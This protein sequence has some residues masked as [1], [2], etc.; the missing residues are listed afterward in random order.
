MELKLLIDK[1]SYGF[2]MYV[3]QMFST[4]FATFVLQLIFQWL[5]TIFIY[6]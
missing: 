6:F 2:Y 1:L 4:R 3:I 5:L